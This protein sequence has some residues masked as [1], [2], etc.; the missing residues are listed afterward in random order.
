MI[1]TQ[2]SLYAYFTCVTFIHKEISFLPR[3]LAISAI[4]INFFIIINLL[5]NPQREGRI[6]LGHCATDADAAAAAAAVST[7]SAFYKNRAA[8]YLHGYDHKTE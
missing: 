7:C 8:V 6:V 5:Y 3:V 4:F 1:N 2:F